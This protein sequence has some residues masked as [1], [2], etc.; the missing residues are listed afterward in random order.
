[1]NA[2]DD[3]PEQQSPAA[4]HSAS[5]ATRP[6][7]LSEGPNSSSFFG[8]PLPQRRDR[9]TI[10]YQSTS[11]NLVKNRHPSICAEWSF[12][13]P[14]F[15]IMSAHTPSRQKMKIKVRNKTPIL[16]QESPILCQPSLHH[17]D[18]APTPESGAI[19]PD[20]MPIVS[21]AFILISAIYGLLFNTL[22]LWIVL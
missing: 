17:F 1:M 7:H 15:F 8:S 6:P 3:A 12:V 13:S 20:M 2:D 16:I 22:N 19:T 21:P 14:L 18:T 4:A 5:S 10:S 11:L 9:P